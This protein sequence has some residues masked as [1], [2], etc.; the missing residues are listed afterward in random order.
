MIF[1]DH[2]EEEQFELAIAASLATSDEILAKRQRLQ[3]ES[4]VI[5]SDTDDEDKADLYLALANSIQDVENEKSNNL[6]RDE[7]LDIALA[8]SIEENDKIQNGFWCCLHCSWYSEEFNFNCSM[9]NSKQ[10]QR[11][12]Q[13]QYQRQQLLHQQHLQMQQEQHHAELQKLLEQQSLLEQQQL[14]IA[15]SKKCGLPGCKLRAKIFHFCSENHRNRATQQRNLPVSEE[16]IERV[17]LGPSGD[18]TAQL[19]RKA[20][21]EHSIVKQQFLDAWLKKEAGRPRVERV[22]KIRNPPQTFSKYQHMETA[23]GNS[24]PRFHGT[25]QNPQ[26]TFGSN[27]STPPC[28]RPDC[29]V[30]SVCQKSFALKYSGETGARVMDLRYGKG[31]YFSATSSKSHDY[32]VESERI[33]I[34]QYGQKFAWRS[35]FLCR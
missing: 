28:D 7:A 9:C 30:C 23:L 25:S 35:M 17:L 34:Q 5:D 24:H 29:R 8:Q 14:E 26:C 22:Y 2:D 31:L 21:P 16:G 11:H 6:I 18:F 20:H 32:N 27:P 1:L 33:L 15:Q 19:L 10:P 12:Q 3:E 13:E 4:I